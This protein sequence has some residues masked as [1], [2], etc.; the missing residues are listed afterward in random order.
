MNSVTQPNYERSDLTVGIVHFGVG[1]FHRSHQAMYLDRLFN[2]GKARDWAIC[3]VGVLPS[4]IRMRDA[5]GSQGMRYT[6]V[7]R[8]PDGTAPART[9]GSIAEYLFAP[10]D[11]E[12]VFEKLADPAVRIVSL[13]ITE[14]GYNVGDDTGEFDLDEPVVVADLQDGA[15]PTTVYGIVAEGVRRRRDRGIAPFTVMSCDNLPG[16]GYV[17]RQSFVAFARAKDVDL[18]EY[19]A[20]EVAFPNSMVDRITPVTGPDERAFVKD[21]Y[22][23]IDAW[24]VV[25]EGFAQWV[26]QTRFTLGR[27]PYE[28]VGVQVVDDVLP[29]EEMKLR[30]LNA[31]HQALAYVGYLSGH[32]FAHEAAMDPL[33]ASLVTR[34]MT[35]EAVPTL[36]PVPGVDL[37]D[38]QQSLMDR[39]ANVHVRDTLLRLATDGSDRIAKFVLP[40]VRDRIAA[41][42][43]VELAAAIAASW[44]TFAR[45]VDEYG[46]RIP[47]IDRQLDAVR[48]IVAEA[49]DDPERF[50]SAGAAVFGGLATEPV[51]VTPFVRAYRLIREFGAQR[52]LDELVGTPIT[53]S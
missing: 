46:E 13:T 24:P 32:R 37:D 51:F 38:Y 30:L 18:G 35:E 17:A 15:V 44:A 8:Y 11:P 42:E 5:L 28:D 45:G 1:N 12:A 6:L 29:Y 53:T 40:V 22:G 47:M 2:A 36:D 27:P 49:D 4:D 23:V 43:S 34:Y 26:L 21:H 50:L 20:R 14:G 39:F 16:N 19:M 33:I 3:G 31:S 41:G 48:H 10:D 9:I 52:A 25:S 7:E